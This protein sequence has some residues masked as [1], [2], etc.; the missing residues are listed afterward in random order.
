M[1][2]TFNNSSGRRGFRAVHS[3]RSFGH[4]TSLSKIYPKTAHS[5]VA[6]CPELPQVP[7][8]PCSPDMVPRD[9][10]IFPDMKM[11]LK[12]NRF[13]DTEEIKR[14]R[15]RCR[16]LWQTVSQSV[17]KVLRKNGRTAGCINTSQNLPTPLMNLG[18]CSVVLL[19]SSY[20]DSS[21]L[22]STK[23]GRSLSHS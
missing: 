18:K 20:W 13:Q 5:R 2:L 8:P 17:P 1:G 12:E 14:E 3:D 10:F 16:W 11:L 9:S 7:K 15:R 21:T 22:S 19:T 23:T 4:D 6:P